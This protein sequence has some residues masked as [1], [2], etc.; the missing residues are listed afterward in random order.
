VRGGETV[1]SVNRRCKHSHWLF[2]Q[3]T[4]ARK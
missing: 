4:K 1:A 3:L 2:L